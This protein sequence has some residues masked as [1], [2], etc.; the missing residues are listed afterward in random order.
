M[1]PLTSQASQQSQNVPGSSGPVLQLGHV[2]VLDNTIGWR[3]CMWLLAYSLKP[4]VWLCESECE[5]NQGP[6]CLE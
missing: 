5:C 3:A 1:K 2:L 6:V 4:L